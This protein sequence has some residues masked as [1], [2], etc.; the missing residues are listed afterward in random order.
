MKQLLLSAIL[1]AFIFS[2]QAQ[3]KIAEVTEDAE[4][5]EVSLFN[6][7]IHVKDDYNGDTTFVRVGRHNI[8]IVEEGNKT[9]I[10][11]HKDHDWDGENGWQKKKRFN[12]HWAGF[13]LGFNGFDETDYSMYPFDEGFMDLNQ[14]KSMEVN[15]N[16][17]EYNIALQKERG[18]IGIVTGVG[19]S[20]NN[21]RFDNPI[22]VDKEDGMLVPVSLDGDNIKKSKLMVSYITVPL[23]L[24]FQIPVNDFSNKIH[25]S[26]GI[27]GGINIGSHTK[28]K[29][30]HSKS[31]DRGSFNVNLFKYAATARIGL[32]D[33]S[34]YATYNL[35]PLFDTDKG[36]KLV[37][38]SIG[39]SLVNI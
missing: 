11:V 7:K 31:K 4:K 13:E 25:I 20:M 39:I 3:S 12:G 36:P 19:Y 23:L 1:L 8:E 28:V 22:T 35:S 24:E 29:M 37:P 10:D 15:V 26:G 38:F 33:I 9:H 32:K 27:I 34:L 16:F 6:D 30:D 17:L 21:F 2:A 5:T 14:P 18:N